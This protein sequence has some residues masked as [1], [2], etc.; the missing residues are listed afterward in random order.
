MVCVNPACM[1]VR[2]PYYPFFLVFGC[3][4]FFNC[5]FNFSK[6]KT[7]NPKSK[8]EKF[9]VPNTSR[10]AVAGWDGIRCTVT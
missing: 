3:T 10:L 6:N 1:Q 7:T 2:P 4:V 8:G 9:L 5:N